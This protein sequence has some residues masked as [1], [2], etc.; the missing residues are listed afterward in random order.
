MELS[1]TLWTRKVDLSEHPHR[2][3]E[4]ST[5]PLTCLFLLPDS[6]ARQREGPLQGWGVPASSGWVLPT[7]W[8]PPTPPGHTG[9]SCRSSRAT[10][11]LSAGPKA[12][13]P[14]SVPVLLPPL[15]PCA[16]RSPPRPPRGAIAHLP[17]LRAAPAA[18]DTDPPHQACGTPHYPR[19]PLGGAPARGSQSEP[20]AQ[21]PRPCACALVL[22]RGFESFSTQTSAAGG[23][24]PGPGEAPAQFSRAAPWLRFENSAETSGH[25][26]GEEE[27]S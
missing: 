22:R 24:C 26:Y 5:F 8:A 14:L 3:P 19:L 10:P 27:V 16:R 21:G 13:R 7:P 9:R 18:L 6:P 1:L 23:R 12:L 11:A 4:S 20:V 17:Y 2:G 25:A 15:S